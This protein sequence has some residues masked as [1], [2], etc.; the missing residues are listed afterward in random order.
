MQIIEHMVRHLLQLHFGITKLRYDGGERLER[1]L[2]KLRPPPILRERHLDPGEHVR[3]RCALAYDNVS[4][5]LRN[6]DDA[7]LKIINVQH[8]SAIVRGTEVGAD[9]MALQFSGIADASLCCI[10]WK[11]TRLR[12]SYG[13][14]CND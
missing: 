6:L 5:A 7:P 13:C 3:E 14:A 2:Q 4:K 10:H 12:R 9:V 1:I 11:K 8:A